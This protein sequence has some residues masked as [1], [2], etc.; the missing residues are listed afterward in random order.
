MI[1]L[2]NRPAYGGRILVGERGA[3]RLRMAV[4]HHGIASPIVAAG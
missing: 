2:P 3:D 1:Q 4:Q